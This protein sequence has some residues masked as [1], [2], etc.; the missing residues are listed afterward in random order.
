MKKK[1]LA[2]MLITCSVILAA[3][4]VKDNSKTAAKVTE[5]PMITQKIVVTQEPE[6]TTT[7][8]PVYQPFDGDTS[9]YVYYYQD[10]RNKAWE[11]IKEDALKELVPFVES[12]VMYML[13]HFASGMGNISSRVT[14]EIGGFGNAGTVI[15]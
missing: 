7:P 3:C 9:T 12:K 8:V 11:E 2:G 15:L 6:A 1:T 4:G 13:G 5:A 10:E 14:E